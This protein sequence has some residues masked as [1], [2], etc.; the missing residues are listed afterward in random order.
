MVDDDRRVYLEILQE[1]AGKYG[2][3]VLGYCVMGALTC[4]AQHGRSEMTRAIRGHSEHLE[5]GDAVP[6]PLGFFALDQE[7]G[8][9]KATLGT[10]NVAHVPAS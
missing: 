7:H 6:R 2:L 1:Q 4:E 8:E 10:H 3:E 9:G 5:T